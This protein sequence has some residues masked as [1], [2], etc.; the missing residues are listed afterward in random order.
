MCQISQ[1]NKRRD[2]DYRNEKQKKNKIFFSF[3]ISFKPFSHLNLDVFQKI[4]A[5]VCNI[6]LWEKSLRGIGP[7]GLMPHA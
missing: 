1:W 2:F 4:F 6:P 5:F 7:K 3:S